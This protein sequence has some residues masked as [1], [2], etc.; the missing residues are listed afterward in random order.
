MHMH[1]LLNYYH[2]PARA[3]ARYGALYCRYY[4]RITVNVII[5]FKSVF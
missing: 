4:S 3:L 1:D 2:L 5:Q